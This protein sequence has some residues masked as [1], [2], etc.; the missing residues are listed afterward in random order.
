MDEKK[1]TAK[2]AAEINETSRTVEMELIKELVIDPLSKVNVYLVLFVLR[3][4]SMIC[5]LEL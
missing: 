4:Y 5:H 1:A 2:R 3:L